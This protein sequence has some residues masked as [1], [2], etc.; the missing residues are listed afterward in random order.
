M[1]QRVRKRQSRRSC[2]TAS[3]RHGVIW[4]RRKSKNAPLRYTGS[5]CSRDACSS[6]RPHAYRR[7]RV[8]HSQR[9][10]ADCPVR[11]SYPI[12]RRQVSALNP[13]KFWSV[14]DL[15]VIGSECRVGSITSNPYS[16]KPVQWAHPRRI[17]EVPSPAKIG[18]EHRMKVGR[19]QLP[20]VTRHE[21]RRNTER[22]TECNPEVGKVSTNAGAPCERVVSRCFCTA[23]AR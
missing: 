1:F 7:K 3:L 13:H 6:N 12:D 21:P 8:H 17:K 20:A 18:F 9:C 14:F 15:A 4:R 16:H 23:C 11:R 2:D 22:P 19:F 5:G 10:G